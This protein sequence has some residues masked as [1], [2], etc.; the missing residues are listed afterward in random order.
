MNFATIGQN[1]VKLFANIRRMTDNSVYQMKFPPRIQ[2]L[3]PIVQCTNDF[4]SLYGQALFS[5]N[6]LISA[7]FRIQR[8]SRNVSSANDLIGF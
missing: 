1:I 8:I 6:I 5:I 3:F 2:R 7:N 4:F